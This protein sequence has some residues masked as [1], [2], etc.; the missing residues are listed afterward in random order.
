MRRGGSSVAHKISKYPRNVI[1]A[2]D[3][4]TVLIFYYIVSA[5]PKKF[6]F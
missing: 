6:R 3:Q 5:P 4:D 1:H 2:S